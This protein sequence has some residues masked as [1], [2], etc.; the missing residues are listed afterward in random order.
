MILK[1]LFLS[2][3]VFLMSNGLFAGLREKQ[4]G[5]FYFT[6]AVGLLMAGGLGY[7]IYKKKSG[8]QDYD[9]DEAEE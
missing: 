3:L 7:A 6:V 9:A 4:G 1:S 2:A 5:V 8:G